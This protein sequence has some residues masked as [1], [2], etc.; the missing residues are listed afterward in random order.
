MYGDVVGQ[1]VCK[2]CRINYF[3]FRAGQISCMHCDPGKYTVKEG[4]ASC[5]ECG[6]GKYGDDGGCQE[7][8]QGWHRTDVNGVDLTKCIQCDR[9]ET[10]TIG[11]KSCQS[12]SIGQ[13]GITPGNCTACTS[14]QYQSEKKQ[15]TCLLCKNGELPNEQQTGCEKPSHQV[16]EDCD[17]INQFLNNSSPNKEDWAC[18]SCPLGACCKGNVDW[19]EVKALQGWWR[20]PWSESNKTFKRCPYLDDC[21]GMSL[22][23]ESSD[24]TTTT[25]ITEGCHPTTTGPLCSICIDR[26]NR[27]GSQCNPCDDSSVPMRVGILLGIIAF[28]FAII[29]YCRRKVRKKWQ[30]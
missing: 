16:K 29:M 27:D 23:A 5:Q 11:A 20:V 17:Y 4:E 21:R 24:T 25:N 1:R 10:S 12:C 14:G 2:Q 8:P 28:M 6:A 26:Y 3:S 18:Q 19:S 9:G 13:Y 30:M 15:T 22:T 7:C